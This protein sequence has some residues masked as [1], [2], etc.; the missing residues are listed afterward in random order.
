MSFVAAV[1]ESGPGYPPDSEP[2]K[3]AIL[4]AEQ[5]LKVLSEYLTTRASGRDRETPALQRIVEMLS[6]SEN[7]ENVN[8]YPDGA[9]VTSFDFAIDHAVMSFSIV[10]SVWGSCEARPR[11][12]L[13]RKVLSVNQ[14]MQTIGTIVGN[15]HQCGAGVASA[16][17]RA[18]VTALTEPQPQP[19]FG[20]PLYVV[21]HIRQTSAV[22]EA[23]Y[24]TRVE[25]ER[26]RIAELYG[27]KYIT[28]PPRN[29][30]SIDDEHSDLYLRGL[31]ETAIAK[32]EGT[33]LEQEDFL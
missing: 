12:N 32:M 9:S 4:L 18:L 27:Q 25:N 5:S 29:L 21:D 31:E 28:V 3:V 7:Y 6:R 20:Q 8:W 13:P 33:F 19:E 24:R 17:R 14:T 2:I 16:H 26:V 11:M 22:R 30:E 1:S 10:V 23:E 15:I